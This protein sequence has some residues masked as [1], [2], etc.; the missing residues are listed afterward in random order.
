M[1]RTAGFR[2]LLTAMAAMAVALPATAQ[3]TT[4]AVSGTVTTIQ[5]AVIPGAT[6]VLIS[7]SRGTRGA[8]A[9]T[10]QA[11]AWTFP[12]TAPGSHA[13]EVT[14]TGYRTF[15]RRGVPVSVG[16]R[17]SVGALAL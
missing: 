2:T 4:G 8:P 6:V 13:I 17:A 7:E 1:I 9:T 16:D 3:V 10:V 5:G 15:T 12:D 14:M 11:G